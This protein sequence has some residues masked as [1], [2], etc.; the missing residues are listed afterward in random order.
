MNSAKGTGPLAGIRVV[1]FA[2]IGPGPL[3]GMLLGDLGAEVLLVE[4]A[5]PADIGIPRPRRFEVPHRGK[6]SLK[7]DLKTVLAREVAADLI[8]AADVLIE[9]FRPGTMERLGLG[10]EECLTRNPG[11]VY[12]RLTGYGQSGPLAAVAGHDLNYISLA[13]VLHA[14]GRAGGPPTPPLNLVGDY[15]GGSMLLAFGITSALVERAQSGRGQVID[16]AMVEGASLLMSSFFGMHAAGLN[17]RPRGENLLDGGAPFY[18][19]YECADGRYVAFAAIEHK[20]RSVF[21]ERTGF[22]E[23][24]LLQADDWKNWPAVRAALQAFFAKRSR[25]EWC[26][27]L[28]DC[29]ACV[30]PVLAA[31]EVAHHRHNVERGTFPAWGGAVQPAPAPRFSRTSTGRPLLPPEPGERGS[32]RAI[33]WGIS[34]ERLNSALRA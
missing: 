13:G 1:E 2:G 24:A 18:D 19:V 20:F 22:P 8:K 31:E 28:E 33:E 9:G 6:D 30:T 17:T 11:L 12:G 14:T 25:D 23:L 10:P 26:E 5:E 27:L 16:A 29:D 34:Q 21:A 7:L 32:A 15:A 4:R 3:C